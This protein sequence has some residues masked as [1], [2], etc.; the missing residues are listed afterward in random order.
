MSFADLFDHACSC[1][2]CAL[3]LAA[4]VAAGCVLWGWW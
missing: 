3:L 1:W 4:T 2:R